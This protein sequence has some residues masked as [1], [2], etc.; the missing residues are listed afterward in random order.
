MGGLAPGTARFHKPPDFAQPRFQCTPCVPSI[1]LREEVG[2]QRGPLSQQFEPDQTL[3][4]WQVKL[5]ASFME[6][7]RSVREVDLPSSGHFESQKVLR[8]SNRNWNSLVDETASPAE[9]VLLKHDAADPRRIRVDLARL[10]RLE[11][12]LVE[13]SRPMGESGACEACLEAGEVTFAGDDVN[14]MSGSI[15]GVTRYSYAADEHRSIAHML[16]NE[17]QDCGYVRSDTSSN[18]FKRASASIRRP[19]DRASGKPTKRRAASSV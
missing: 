7:D 6:E 15:G 17:A 12:V 13:V 9:Q 2:D 14:V 16:V 19:G 1:F 5:R 4:K 8:R 11:C 3:D 10:A 18:T